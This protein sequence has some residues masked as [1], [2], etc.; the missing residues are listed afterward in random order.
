MFKVVLDTNVVVSAALNSKGL[1]ALLVS[2]A[3]SRKIDLCYSA[4]ILQEYREVLQREKFHLPSDRVDA[5]VDDLVK[6]GTQ[7]NPLQTL[8]ILTRDP[9]DNRILECA[10]QARADYLVTGNK[11]HFPFARFANTCIVNPNEFMAQQGVGTV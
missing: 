8:T 2:M 9:Q 10:Q 3:I 6:A 1:P 7:V 11:K 4:A 5:L